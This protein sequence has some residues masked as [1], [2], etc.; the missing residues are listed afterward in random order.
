MKDI[1]I[2]LQEEGKIAKALGIRLVAGDTEEAQVI[3]VRS[4]FNSLMHELWGDKY[5]IDITQ[6]T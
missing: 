1:A 2:H 5:R 6:R 4:L 3:Y